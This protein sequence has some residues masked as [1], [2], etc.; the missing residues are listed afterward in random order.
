MNI[1]KIHNSISDAEKNKNINK[2]NMWGIIHNLR[3]SEGG[4]IW[5]YL[6]E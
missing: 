3:K 6:E 5:K 1:V 4:F 2:N